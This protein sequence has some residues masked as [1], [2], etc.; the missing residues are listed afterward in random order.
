ML[1]VTHPEVGSCALAGPLAIV[2]LP[3][4]VLGL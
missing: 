1:L 3:L 4:L 2:S